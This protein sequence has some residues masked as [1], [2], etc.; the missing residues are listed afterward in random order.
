LPRS[1]AQKRLA[2]NWVNIVLTIISVTQGFLFG[3]LLSKFPNAFNA[4]R[5]SC[6]STI[7]NCNYI[8][9]VLFL[10]CIILLLRVFQSVIA[11]VLDD[12]STMPHLYEFYFMAVFGSLE[13]YLFSLFENK[14]LGDSAFLISFYQWGIAL[15]LLAVIGYYMS[16]L[17][18]RQRHKKL[19]DQYYTECWL[20]RRNIFGTITIMVIQFLLLFSSLGIFHFAQSGNRQIP[21]VG[22]MIAI[23]ILNTK[24]SLRTTFGED[25]KMSKSVTQLAT[26]NLEKLEIKISPAKKKDITELCNLLMQHFDYVYK[27]LFASGDDEDIP[28]SKMLESVLEANAGK[29]ALGYES[30][31]VARPKGKRNQI[32]GMLLL[33]HSAEK[34]RRLMTAW[35]IIVIVFLNL[36]MKGLL[37]VWRNWWVIHSVSRKMSAN[38]LHIVYLAVSDNARNL[39]VGTQLLKYARQIAKDK[40]KTLITLCVRANNPKAK[41]FFIRQGFSVENYPNDKADTKADDLLGQGAIIRMVDKS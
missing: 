36:G 34:W 7:V 5:N 13:Y 35:S 37:Q 24:D 15:S 17:Q 2:A 21:F 40:N 16:L 33:K 28:V 22:V 38:E 30:F 9:L 20:Q 3:Y 4:F 8:I 29:H 27:A 41:D 39:K 14:Q 23:L 25:G 12:E 18:F 10:L 26:P 1:Q 31:L 11:G 6:G 32:V 19:D